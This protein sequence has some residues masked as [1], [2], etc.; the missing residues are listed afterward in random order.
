MKQRT[1][2]FLDRYRLDGNYIL[3]PDRNNA[4]PGMRAA[5]DANGNPVLIKIW[6]KIAGTMDSEL[7]ELW[8]NEVRQLHRLGGYPKAYDTIAIL[9]QADEDE[10]GFYLVLEPGQRRPLN[11]LLRDTPQD[12]WVSNPRTPTNRAKLWRNLIRICSG[13]ETLHAQGLLHK[14]INAWA[15]LTT[16]GQEPDFQLTGFEWSVRLVGVA[17]RRHRLGRSQRPSG[18]AA[19]FLKDWQDLGI[20][21]AQLLDVQIPKLADNRIPASGVADHMNVDEIRL[22]RVLLQ[23]ERVARLDGE[24]VENRI[25]NLL[26]NLHAQI[27]SMDP[28]LHLVVRL[29]GNSSLSQR[30]R[31]GSDNDIEIDGI[32]E[33][34]NFI[35][36]DLGASPRLLAIRTETDTSSRMIIRGTKLT[37]SLNEFLPHR[38]GSTPTWEFAYCDSCERHDPAPRNVLGSSRLDSNSLSILPIGSARNRFSR[39]RGKLRSWETLKREFEAEAL[40][41]D[42]DRRL[43]Q[44]LALTQLLEA[45]FAA[46]DAFPVEVIDSKRSAVQDIWTLEVRIGMDVERETLSDALGIKSPTVRFD[47]VLINDRR[48]GDW[49]L[50]ESRHIGMREPTDTTWRFDRRKKDRSGPQTYIFVGQNPPVYL[51]APAMISGEFVGRDIQFRRRLKALRALADHSELLWMIVDPR[52]RILDTH[53]SIEGDPVLTELDISKRDALISIVKTLPLYLIQGPPGVGKTRLVRELVKR[54]FS[55]ERYARL[56]LSAQSNAAVDHLLETLHE[57]FADE[58]NDILV[59]RCRAPDRNTVVGPYEI[60]RQA[61]DIVQR[62]AS[63]PLVAESPQGL[64]QRVQALCVE[65]GEPVAEPT[66]EYDQSAQIRYAK[67]AIE[68]LVVRAANVVFATTNSRELERLIEERGQFDWTVVEEAGKATGSE[69]VA[70]L[71]LSYRRLLIGDH[72]QLSPFGSE[73]MVRLLENPDAVAKALTVGRDFIGRT[74]RDSSTDEVL[75]EVNDEDR[76]EFASLCSLAINCVML[77]EHLLENEF[78]LQAERPTARKIADILDQQHRMHPAISQ[79]ISDC[80]YDGKLSTHHSAI[81]RYSEERCPVRSLDSGRIPNTPIVVINMPYIQTEIGMKDSEQR[82]RWHNPGEVDAVF[83]AVRLLDID[84][85]TS[86]VPSLAVLSPYSEQVRQLQQRFDV[87]GTELSALSSFIPA[88]GPNKYVGTVDSFQ[89]KEAD[90]VVVSLVRNNHHSGITSALGFLSNFRRMNVLLSRAK[91]RLILVCSLEFL[92]TVLSAS[93]PIS[94]VGSE[95]IDF[96]SKLLRGIRVARDEGYATVVSWDQVR[97]GPKK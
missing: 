45:L 50:T 95:R 1:R 81:V 85:S 74:L 97:G 7:R 91:W 56:L 58:G 44:S 77:F 71:L 35:G 47:E 24:E 27:A 66:S 83:E 52:Q 43:H 40:P 80:F 87:E 29:G 13:L 33:Q 75:D 73:Q 16:G 96:L 59:V 41:P 37:Y 69:L 64:Q 22:L 54:T 9:Q 61:R 2:K 36:D 48:S 17:T 5:F 38:T 86:Y 12:H 31:E 15:I 60:D 19:S 39:L 67:Q 23:I 78:V 3:R 6:P 49:V 18:E 63:S 76:D 84:R 51:R 10:F 25:R 70:P 46:A 68:G 88:V 42:R 26:R 89:G 82:P 8:H 21:V 28:K 92:E 79:L 14:S 93:G 90:V 57:E 94:G 20:L 53:D 11:V 72:K 55:K 4:R 32:Q 65:L 34:L 30:I 62:F